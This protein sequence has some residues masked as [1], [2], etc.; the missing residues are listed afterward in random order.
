[1]HRR[2]ASFPFLPPS[3]FFPRFFSFSAPWRMARMHGQVQTGQASDSPPLPS[4]TFLL[5]WIPGRQLKRAGFF[6]RPLAL[7]ALEQRGRRAFPPFFFFFYL[8]PS[9]SR[10]R[11]SKGRPTFSFLSLPFTACC[12]ICRKGR[13]RCPSY[14]GSRLPFSLFFPGFFFPVV[15][16]PRTSESN[17]RRGPCP[18]CSPSFPPSAFPPLL[19]AR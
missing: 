14:A 17:E 7:T 16:A 19:S 2:P 3:P 12:S 1:M 11:W 9:L 6:F 15:P 10:T 4:S 18:C 13:G 8:L 5:T